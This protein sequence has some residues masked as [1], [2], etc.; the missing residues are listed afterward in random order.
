MKTKVHSGP[1]A[2]VGII[3]D[4]VIAGSYD[5]SASMWKRA[6]TGLQPERF[7]LLHRKIINA[8]AVS[9]DGNKFAT[10]GSD[11]TACI[12]N[13]AQNQPQIV[14]C[15]HP[16]DVE[17]LVFTS[18]STFLLTGGTDGFARLFEAKT[19]RQLQQ[20]SHG[21][22][23]G[24]CCRHPD[25]NVL[26]TGSND[27]KLRLIDFKRGQVVKEAQIHTGP[28][29]AV[30]ETKLGIVSAGHDGKLLLHDFDLGSTRELASFTTTP[31]AL[32]AD[33]SGLRFYVG[34]YDGFTHLW[35]HDDDSPAAFA[36]KQK[37]FSPRAWAHGLAAASDFAVIGSF[38]GAPAL[39]FLSESGTIRIKGTKA[40]VP[41]VSTAALT[42]NGDLLLAG[43]SGRI[44]TISNSE[45]TEQGI[46]TQSAT[47]V[48]QM[49]GPVTSMCG[50]LDR[51]IVG[52]WTGEVMKLTPNGRSWKASWPLHGE[53]T[54]GRAGSP[55]LRVSC[56]NGRVLAG[57]YTGGCVCFSEEN[58]QVLW[59]N[60][61]ATGAI[62]CTD[63]FGDI[64][65][66]TGRYDALR[67]G[68]ART[69]KVMA[70]LPLQTPVS[71]VVAFSPFATEDRPRLA[72]CAGMNEVWF[73]DLDRTE[74]S[75]KT[76]VTYKSCGHNAPVKAL[77][78]L[79]ANTLF[80]GDYNGSIVRHSVGDASSPFLNPQCRNGVSGL[81]V[82]PSRELV[83]TT[84]DGTVGR[85]NLCN[86]Q[87]SF[88]GA[89]EGRL[90][91]VMPSP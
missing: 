80:A 18:C 39:V 56:A 66:V 22:T 70:R 33:P 89:V 20:I 72:V 76:S 49:P 61:E 64:Y 31:K 74:G 62:K 73:V 28:I 8:I 19:G 78:W 16:G 2:A 63:L 50:D 32:A 42:E 86:R 40:P 1:V 45:L 81:I 53:Q 87:C 34:V 88:P 51:I 84:F 29:K 25:A 68:D 15:Q 47:V 77:A 10:G 23:V 58:G 14:R 38:D 54:K 82:T 48:A 37:T 7:W 41:C 57:L 5:G 11:G 75:W 21:K 69:G 52:S 9:P 90:I 91:P 65:C 35:A 43:D 44:Q 55:V 71:D 17:S 12:V 85:Q 27:R 79:D 13:L 24:S 26:V 30:I 59:A 36:P 67:L 60:R 83:W 3:G 6:S 46:G 4:R